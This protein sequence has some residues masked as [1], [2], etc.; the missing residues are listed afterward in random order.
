MSLDKMHSVLSSLAKSVSDNEKLATPILA[1][2]I[3]KALEANPHDQTLGALSVIFEK[4][5]ANNNTF[6]K[7]SEFKQLYTKL[8]SRNTK[9]A[10]L[11]ADELGI[12]EK[13]PEA[14][15]SH[16]ESSNVLEYQVSDP[17]LANALASV[18]D[19]SIPLKEYSQ[20]LADKAIKSVATT[21]DAWNLR[22][23]ALTMM[24]G[25]EKFL[26][27]QADYETPKGL[28]SLLVPLEIVNNKVVEAN[29][30]I[31][32]A[33]PTELNNTNVKA[34]IKAFSGKSLKVTANLILSALTKSAS[35]NREISAVEIALTKL[36]AT[37]EGKSEFFQNSII[38]QKVAEASKKDIELPK[39][40][41][42]ES[43]EKKFASAIGVATFSFGDDKIK[44]A[45]DVI[46]RDII[47]FGYKNPQITVTASNDS[48]IYY[49]VSLNNGKIAFTVPV[50]VE[51]GKINKPN[52]MIC[53]GAMS[54]FSKQSINDLYVNNSTDYKV[55]AVASPQFGL[56]PSDLINNIRAALA[57][58]NHEKAEDAL[59]VLA[60]C[61][62]ETAYATG[63]GLYMSGLAG[64][65][66]E[67]STCSRV[68]KTASSEHPVCG[69]T[70][71]PLHKVYQ[72]KHGNCCPLYRRGMD[73][74]Y[75]GAVFNNSKI[76][77]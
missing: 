76:F 46:A 58:G 31:G 13:E 70:G 47:S 14:A 53:N 57:D 48:T 43:F 7:R 38:G 36:N 6:I 66:V 40:D 1:V 26:V 3:A 2:K 5:A 60:S 45:R 39:S 77:G 10:E 74:T 34:Y 61:D 27:I 56:K 62:N 42:F 69:H 22:P 44:I 32:N 16:D 4:M 11:F 41:E 12:L 49:G 64:N 59:N 15:P 73:E 28:T 17:V 21:L 37:R 75:E 55:A 8:Y 30:F 19:P 67:E 68:I 18:F 33:G 29:A 24:S 71:L 23:S 52:V 25:N 35:E 63:F 50:K 20:P 65:K 51:A 72:D 9:V 54:S